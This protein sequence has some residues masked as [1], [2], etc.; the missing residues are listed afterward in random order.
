[1]KRIT[2]KQVDAFT[3][4]PFTGNPAGVVTDAE[5]LT[6]REMKSIAR[7]MNVSETAYIL[8]PTT[9]RADV[10][11]RWFTPAVEVPLCGHATI[12]SFHALAEEGMLGMNKI[13][14][15]TFRLETKSGVLPVE[16]RK[17]RNRTVT[18]FGLPMPRFQKAKLDQKA[19]AEVLSISTREFDK[20][21]PIVLAGNVYIPIRRLSTIFEMTP[22]FID[23]LRF[24]R[25]EKI[26]GFCVFT[27][28]TVEQ[29]SSVHSRFF[30]PDA[31]INEDPVTGSANGPLG[32]YFYEQGI[33][34]TEDGKYD[35]VG[36]QGDAIG[37]KGRVHIELQVRNG[38]VRSVSVGGEAVTILRGEILI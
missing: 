11:I 12:G 30:A 18:K 2:I 38:Q 28:E 10:R 15:Y 9:L 23:M 8:P 22:N 3:T 13:G 25:Q 1:M 27:T 14:A 4:T 33:L 21:L 26:S 19:L 5:G 29:I 6:A 16:V 35:I 24:G 37:R 17:G 34:G 32:V 31:G 36:E 7:E 20:R